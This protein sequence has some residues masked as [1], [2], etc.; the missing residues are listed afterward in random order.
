MSGFKALSKDGRLEG[1]GVSFWGGKTWWWDYNLF[2]SLDVDMDVERRE[3]TT[4]R[5]SC[6]R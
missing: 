3:E 5:G 1:R 6:G 4:V 2:G